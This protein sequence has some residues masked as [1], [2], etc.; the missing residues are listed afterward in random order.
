MYKKTLKFLL[1]IFLI[2][3]IGFSFSTCFADENEEEAKVAEVTSIS[4]TKDN[5]TSTPA[6]EIYN[7]DL[8]LFDNKVVMDKLVD[9]NVFIFGTDVEVTGQ[10]NGN[11]FVCANKIKFDNSYVRNSI[12]ACGNSIY[13]NGACNDLYV[14]TQNLEMTYD[15]YVVRDVKAAAKDVIF[16]AAVGRDVDL[17][18]S[19]I[20]IGEEDKIPVI[21]GNFRY[22]APSELTIPEGVMTDNGTATYTN[23]SKV[24]NVKSN[25]ADIVVNFLICIVTVVVIYALLKAFAPKCIEKINNNKFNIKSILKYFGFGLATIILICILCTILLVIRVGVKLAFVLGLLFAIL[26]IVAVPV[27]AIAITNIFKSVLKIEKTW[28]FY[29]TLALVNVV[30]YALTLI[31]IV[32]LLLSLI[33]KTIAI[34]MLVCMLLPKKELTDEELKAIAE[35]KEKAKALKE[36]KKQEKLEAKKAKKEEKNL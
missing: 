26:C 15:S 3:A 34:G 10:V 28:L 4:D 9:G 11:L 32:G 35:K 8:Y 20:D 19:S 1:A 21:Y 30:F 22:T 13:Y 33:I 29:V 36:Q 2:I 5:A 16:K 27:F 12:Y 6:E 24:E 31:P 25:I 14:A 18:Y 7:G 17:A 23:S